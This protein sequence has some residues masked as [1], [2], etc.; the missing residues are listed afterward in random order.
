MQNRPNLVAPPCRT[1]CTVCD[2]AS[3]SQFRQNS[4]MKSRLFSPCV[5]AQARQTARYVF[6]CAPSLAQKSINFIR[7][8]FDKTDY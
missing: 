8:H 1:G 3:S 4:Y 2:G 6:A 5:V 7:N